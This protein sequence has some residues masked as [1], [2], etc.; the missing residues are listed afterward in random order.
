[1]KM[2]QKVN[3]EKNKRISIGISLSLNEKER[4]QAL[5]KANGLTLS[6][7]IRM[8]TLTAGKLKGIEDLENVKE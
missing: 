2:S 3:N 1:M 6:S 7:Y 5:A 8:M 4:L